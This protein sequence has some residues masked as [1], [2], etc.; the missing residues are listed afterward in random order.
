MYRIWLVVFFTLLSACST[1]NTHQTKRESLTTLVEAS[2]ELK[3]LQSVLLAPPAVERMWQ[4]QIKHMAG[5]NTQV[6]QGELVLAFD[7]KQVRDRMLD[8]Q[9]ELATAKKELENQ[10][11]KQEANEEELKL[12]LAEM[13]M[14]YD[15]AKRRAEI[16]DNSRSE[17]ERQKSVLDF[18]IAQIDLHLANEKLT[19]HQQSKQRNIKLASAKVERLQGEVREL[20]QSIDKLQV[21]APFDGIA[22]Y[23]ADWNG[24]KPVVGESVNF[25]QAVMEIAKPDQLQIIAQIREADSGQVKPGQKVD[26]LLSGSQDIALSGKV[27]SLGQVFRN[28]S[29]QDKRRIIDA[30]ITLDNVDLN[31]MRPGM[32]ARVKI[33]AQ[34]FDQALTLPQHL[35]KTDGQR[36]WVLLA[37]GTERDVQ[38]SSLTQGRAVIKAGLDEGER[39]LP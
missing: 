30:A 37:D 24:E 10:T 21:H 5:E 2:G 18:K 25:G 28:M 31:T 38:L 8:K 16:V 35:V 39:V 11:L 14:N 29:R 6:K 3:P 19:H 7:D 1:E 9:A 34:Q 13:Q 12:S 36:H 17:L 33:H 32:T 26:I 23:K 4:Y 15:K 20:K 22:L 27:E